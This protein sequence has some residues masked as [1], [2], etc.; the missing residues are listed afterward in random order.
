[1][2]LSLFQRHK[3][4]SQKEV[5]DNDGSEI[6]TSNLPEHLSQVFEITQ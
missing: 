2:L 5:Q 1:M 6:M 4:T 3:T